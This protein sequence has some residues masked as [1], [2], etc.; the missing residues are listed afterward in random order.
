MAREGVLPRVFAYT[1]KRYGSPVTGIAVWS[2]TNLG[3]AV[4]MYA[5]G[6]NITDA[7][8][9]FGTFC[10]WCGTL[11]YGLVGA[12]VIGWAYRRH[13]LSLSV[14]AT[15]LVGVGVMGIAFYYTVVPLPPYPLRGYLWAFIGIVVASLV[16]YA[17][18][19]WRAPKKVARIGTMQE[20][21]IPD[22]AAA[23]LE[24]EPELRG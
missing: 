8:G 4:V 17:V 5:A 9:F 12:A 16:V 6:Y 2:L 24:P 20:E 19:H 1:S 3:F 18:L 13:E 15:G 14:I 11:Y 7:F 10:G 21:I 22:S 23:R